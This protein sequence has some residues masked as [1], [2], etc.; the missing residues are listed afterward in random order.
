MTT[1]DTWRNLVGA[2]TGAVSG[3][4]LVHYLAPHNWIESA[5]WLQTA[6]FFITTV[7]VVI[8]SI[9]GYWHDA[10]WQLLK[11]SAA[12]SLDISTAFARLKQSQWVLQVSYAW[13]LNRVRLKLGIRT[14]R[15]AARAICWGI[16][17]CIYAPYWLV[18]TLYH[19][20][21]ARMIA[22]LSLSIALFT[23]TIFAVA[24]PIVEWLIGPTTTIIEHGRVVSERLATLLDY[25][26][27][28]AFI[29][30]VSTL[31]AAMISISIQ[32]ANGDTNSLDRMLT[33]FQQK[34]LL[35]F[36]LRQYLLLWCML[37]TA[38]GGVILMMVYWVS[39]AGLIMGLVVF[40]IAFLCC[41]V[42]GFYWI[43]RRQ[44]HWPC[45]VV[46][47]VVTLCVVAYNNFVYDNDLWAWAYGLF[48][49]VVSGGLLLFL[50]AIT[51]VVVE[52]TKAGYYLI[53]LGLEE[54]FTKASRGFWV[55][56]SSV[57]DKALDLVTPKVV[58][59][60]R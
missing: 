26:I 48:A 7:A 46:T 17:W 18:Y 6:N 10:I 5:F 11:H 59:V 9:A 3:I 36:V 35:T 47:L 57:S 12:L 60:T 43:A 28:T 41:L 16:G 13:R 38:V 39:G 33:S 37:A 23:I 19:Q 49:G 32:V 4:L 53:N 56:L 50:Q 31:I 25:V 29:T 40:P 1:T 34:N 51:M 14:I 45:V 8:G 58:A 15:R 42:Q 44:G 27:P 54:L 2:L 24:F 30:V 52:G 21:A 20:Q 55:R 22:A